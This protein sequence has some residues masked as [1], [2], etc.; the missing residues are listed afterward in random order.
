MLVQSVA[1]GI[2]DGFKAET[3]PLHKQVWLVQATVSH[4]M[5]VPLR[6]LCATTRRSPRAA[7]ARQMAMY[8]CH[9][10]FSI[11]VTNVA[12]AFGRD[13]STVVH[14]LQRI[15]EMRD[16]VELDSQLDMLEA[17]LSASWSQS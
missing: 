5:G 13:P 12:R 8:L 4:A 1:S 6:A 16:T 14:A 9:V 15:E 11:S 7:L 2:L 17:F 10:V 3:G